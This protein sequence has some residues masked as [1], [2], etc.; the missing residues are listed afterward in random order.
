[1]R[2]AHVTQYGD[3]DEALSVV[4]ADTPEPGANEVRLP[5]EAVALNDVFARKSHPED[6]GEFPERSG[7]DLAGVVDAVGVGAEGSARRW[8]LPRRVFGDCEF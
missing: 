7:S 3:P 6:E 2:T 5:V 4:D 8:S 1:M